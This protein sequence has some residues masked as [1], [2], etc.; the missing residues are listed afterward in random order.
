ME[1]NSN[2]L[3]LK[4]TLDTFI[5]RG[6]QMMGWSQTNKFQP[7]SKDNDGWWWEW[8]CAKHLLCVRGLCQPILM[9]REL[10]L[11]EV[12]WDFSHLCLCNKL[13]QN[14]VGRPGQGDSCTVFYMVIPQLYAA[15]LLHSSRGNRQPNMNTWRKVIQTERGNQ[16]SVQAKAQG[17]LG[18]FKK[19]FL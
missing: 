5:F 4:A 13:L 15:E 11:S 18:L 12:T 17:L 1:T 3:R 7:S 9:R 16:W 19:R 6:T 14:L 8:V 2:K 10:R